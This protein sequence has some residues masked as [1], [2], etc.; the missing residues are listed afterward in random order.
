MNSNEKQVGVHLNGCNNIH[1]QQ[2]K[3]VNDDQCSIQAE[4]SIK[5]VFAHWT[6]H[7]YRSR[8]AAPVNVPSHP[9]SDIH[10]IVVYKYFERIKL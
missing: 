9:E 7:G 4:R 6:S 8:V 5:L 3:L 2:R 10:P 1:R